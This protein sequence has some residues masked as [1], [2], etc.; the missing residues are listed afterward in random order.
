MPPKTEQA[1]TASAPP[2][3][4]DVAYIPASPAFSKVEDEE[5]L[6]AVRSRYRLPAR[7]VLF[8]GH[9]E[10]RK[11]L[12]NLAEAFIAARQDGLGEWHLVIAGP[13]DFGVE[14][15][16]KRLGDRPAAH[17]I[18]FTG[19]VP[20]EDLAALYTLSSA[21][22]FPSQHEGF[23]IPLIEA[24]ACETPILTSNSSALRE[25]AGDAAI[26]IDPFDIGSITAGLGRLMGEESL[27]RQLVQKGR[28]R[29]QRFTPEKTA[30]AIL[31]SYDRL[32][33]SR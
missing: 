28:E 22:A 25:V 15:L 23:G 29:L 26:L 27:R 10:P 30:E 32:F 6:Q 3:D 5:K 17:G 2:D 24:M 9:L 8:V 20:D 7:F 33:I 16:W 12:K 11:N 4:I 1:P 31:A 13:E 14:N 21:L 18:S 19:Y